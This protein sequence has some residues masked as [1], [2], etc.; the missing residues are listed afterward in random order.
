MKRLITIILVLALLLPAAALA[1]D[2]SHAV[3]CWVTYD[4]LTT[5]APAV[6]FIYLAEDHTCF[7]LVHQFG[8]DSDSGIGRTYVGSWKMTADETVEAK[9]GENTTTTLN[10]PS[11]L[12]GVAMDPKTMRIF[13]NLAVLGIH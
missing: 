1:Y 9:I 6:R 4:L 7:F 12:N 10:I 2:E 13:V 8:E 11:D 3:G 5:G